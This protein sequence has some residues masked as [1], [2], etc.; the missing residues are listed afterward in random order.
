[1]KVE[2]PPS[3]L[4]R[5]M[6]APDTSALFRS[7]G[8]SPDTRTSPFVTAEIP[9][10]PAGASYGVLLPDGTIW[11]PGSERR[12]PAPLV[13]RIVVWALAFLVLL[14]AAGDFVIHN[15]PA[16][17]DPLRRMVPAAGGTPSVTTPTTPAHRSGHPGTALGSSAVHQTSPP[18]SGLPQYTTAY[19]ITGTSTYQLAVKATAVTWVQAYKLANGAD[20]GAPLFAG[21]VQPGQTETISAKGP[22]DLEV[23]AGGATVSV[24]SGGKQVGALATPPSAPWHFWLEPTSAKA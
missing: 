18:P 12:L 22:V 2:E 23:S 4:S 17:V 11:Y 15:H 20:V 16:W 13:L 6:L 14:T 21:D 19:T 10:V 8:P 9:A 24:L 7:Y 1:M 5:T 3:G